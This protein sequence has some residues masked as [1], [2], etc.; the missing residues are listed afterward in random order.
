MNLTRKISKFLFL[1]VVLGGGTV[2]CA[3]NR[4]VR[5]IASSTAAYSWRNVEIEGGGFVP[6]LVFHPRAR[7]VLYARTDIGGAY[8]FG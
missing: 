5:E 3:Q 6:G 8:R 1:T 2:V 4:I 7:N